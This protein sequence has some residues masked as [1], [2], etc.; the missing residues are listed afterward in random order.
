MGEADRKILKAAIKRAAGEDQ[1]RHRTI[2]S[3]IVA[4]WSKKLESLKNEVAEVL[5]EEKEEKQ[6]RV[7]Q[8]T[9]VGLLTLIGQ[10][11]QAEMEVKKGQN[12]LEHK[13]EIYSRPARTWFQS[14]RDKQQSEGGS[15]ASFTSISSPTN[16]QFSTEQATV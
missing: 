9:I 10:L 8:L 4:K 13:A 11:R 7:T 5:R 12:M 1:V 16:Y 6:V 3:E 15:H 14:G 2:S